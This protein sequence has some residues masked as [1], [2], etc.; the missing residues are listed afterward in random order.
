ME[1]SEDEKNEI[2]KHLLCS[3]ENDFYKNKNIE[4]VDFNTMSQNISLYK[5][6]TENNLIKRKLKVLENEIHELKNLIKK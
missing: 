3:V 2:R 1:Y 6:I 5:L 4:Q